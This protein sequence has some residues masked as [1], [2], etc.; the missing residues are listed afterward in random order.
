MTIREL[1]NTE[2]GDAIFFRIAPA[3]QHVV[4]AV[5]GMV[6]KT[7]YAGWFGASTFYPGIR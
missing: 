7:A 5:E 6:P 1:P 4:S 3:L 2:P